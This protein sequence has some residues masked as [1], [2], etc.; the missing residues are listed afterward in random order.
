[1]AGQWGMQNG[2]V[3]AARFFNPRAV[4][5]DQAGD[6]Y[7]ADSDNELVREI[8]VTGVVTNLAGSPEQVGSDDGLSG[9]ARFGAIGSF[10]GSEPGPM[11]AALDSAGNLYVSDFFNHTIRKITPDA[12]VATF[13]GS[14]GQPGSLDGSGT[15]AQFNNPEGVA[16]DAADNV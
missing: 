1:R 16:V 15:G 3:I 2:S 10:G 7:V 9:E 8:F 4:A 11:G 5:V 14:V 6:V 12:E 13:A